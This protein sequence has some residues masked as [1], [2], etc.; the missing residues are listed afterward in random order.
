MVLAFGERARHRALGE[1]R[2]LAVVPR[3][4]S[5]LAGGAGAS[6]GGRAA[7][8]NLCTGDRVTV[9]SVGNRFTLRGYARFKSEYAEWVVYDTSLR[10]Q[11]IFKL[12]QQDEGTYWVRGWDTP[13]A[14]ALRVACAL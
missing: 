13:E 9:V 3:E 5:R 14:D 11:S 4:R 7:I 8:K 6:S 12:R 2:G 1:R 10:G